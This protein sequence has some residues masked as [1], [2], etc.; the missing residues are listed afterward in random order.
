IMDP[1]IDGYETYRRVL[2]FKSKQKAIIVSGFSETKRVKAAQKLGAGVY[3]K[4]P[5]LLNKI[6]QAVRAELDKQKANSQ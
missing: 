2:E 3:V 6:G 4:K 5:Y 1:G